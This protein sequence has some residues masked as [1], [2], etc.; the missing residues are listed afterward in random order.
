VV[1]GPLLIAAAFAALIAGTAIAV[2]QQPRVYRRPVAVPVYTWTGFYVGGNVGYSWGNARTEIAGSATTVA[3]PFFEGGFP[4]N[5]VAFADSNTVRLNGVIGGGQIGYNIQF[6]PR[7]VLGFEADIQGSGERGS[8]A[9]AH[10]FSTTPC[11]L[12][13][14]FPPPTCERNG[15]LNG[16]AAT[17]YD[18]KISW[19]GTV[20]GRLGFLISDQI[21]LYG[22]GGLAYGHVELSGI[23]NVNGSET[24]NL[25]PPSP[26]PPVLPI[27]PA[28][29][30]FSESRTKVGYAVG[31]GIEGK[32]SYLLPA[33]WT[34]KAEY[35][36]VDLG[37][38]DTVAPFPGAFVTFREVFF[39]L[40]PFTGAITTHTRFTDNIVR[41][42]LNYKFGNY[43]APVLTR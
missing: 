40:S 25:H 31:G 42:G 10:P 27:T 4:G 19:F 28:T 2:A 16:V 41:V 8:N 38:L 21:L 32:C 26:V 1:K 39:F 5:N 9:F 22:T 35:L 3:V 17:A 30:A 33:G 7:W 29:T 14:G 24:T 12:A 18:A 11:S 23:T 20:R 36:Y 37:S 13:S 15:T 6:S 34:W 43:Y